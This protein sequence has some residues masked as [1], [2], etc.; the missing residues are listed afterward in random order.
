[1]ISRNFRP[2]AERERMISVESAGSG[3]T[4]RSSFRFSLAP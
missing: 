4:V 1:V 3:W 2:S